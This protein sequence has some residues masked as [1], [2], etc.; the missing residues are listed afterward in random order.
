MAKYRHRTFEM[1]EFLDE[2]VSALTPRSTGS[3]VESVDPALWTFE[4]FETS[5]REGVTLITFK[6]LTSGE[7]EEPSR[8]LPDELSLIARSLVNNSRVVMD[9]EG[10]PEFSAGSIEALTQFNKTLQTKGSRL[11]LCN[12][13]PAVH[14][15][16]FPNREAT[17][18]R[19]RAE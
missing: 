8:K 11:A 3:S 10:L 14:A 6:E 7:D 2:A 16:F 1:F 4:Y 19:N 9:F 13:E 18:S 15:S 12:L 5:R 17:K